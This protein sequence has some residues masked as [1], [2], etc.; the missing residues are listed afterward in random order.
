M[1]CFKELE[2]EYWKK[3]I[4]NLRELIQLE[5]DIDFCNS[6]NFLPKISKISFPIVI[7]KKD[8]IEEK[9]GCIAFIKN[10]SN[11]NKIILN[12]KINLSYQ[13]GTKILISTIYSLLHAIPDYLKKEFSKKFEKSIYYVDIEQTFSCFLN[14]QE[15]DNDLKIYDNSHNLAFATF[16]I[17]SLLKYNESHICLT[18]EITNGEIVEVGEILKKLEAVLL[19]ENIEKFFI[20]KANFKEV[21][22][23]FKDTKYKKEIDDNYI[24]INRN[25]SLKKNPLKI[26]GVDSLEDVFIELY[27]VNW[28]DRKEFKEVFDLSYIYKEKIK[29]SNF[30]KIKNIINLFEDSQE[31]EYVE[32][33]KFVELE[34]EDSSK[35]SSERVNYEVIVEDLKKN[36]NSPPNQYNIG[37]KDSVGTGKSTILKKILS[38]F[39]E[40]EKNDILPVF[41]ELALYTSFFCSKQYEKL[42]YNSLYQLFSN[43]D[44]RNAFFSYLSDNKEKLLFFLDAFDELNQNDTKFNL[45]SDN[46]KFI[47][48]SR[49]IASADSVLPNKTYKL[50][51]L[52]DDAIEAFID[53]NLQGDNFFSFKSKIKENNFSNLND[54]L[55]NPLMLS[56]LVFIVKN[57]K[58][59]EYNDLLNNTIRTRVVAKAVEILIEKSISGNDALKADI[60]VGIELKN[61]FE[62]QVIPNN[63]VSD[64]ILSNIGFDFFTN[65]KDLTLKSDFDD[66]FSKEV[67]II[68]NINLSETKSANLHYMET[69]NRILESIYKN[70]RLLELTLIE[71]DKKQIEGYRFSHQLFKE[72]FTAN[73]VV[74]DFSDNLELFEKWIN[75]NKFNE[76]YLEVIPFVGGILD[77]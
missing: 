58:E 62:G 4:E 27:G 67:S 5:R 44:E 52:S 6:G 55:R 26:I 13:T 8:S 24:I 70:T 54:F 14:I 75:N 32:L 60:G 59:E 43:E 77:M 57:K 30:V 28:Y 74:Y 18:G 69:R 15:P 50:L 51:S 72:Y 9:I 33:E 1:P 63:R 64:K 31:A 12:A 34:L 49:S 21:S 29:N 19:Y 17:L 16:I 37:I 36:F 76:K 7:E 3:K 45:V 25:H 23:K 71:K 2:L 53:K 22:E 68:N 40:K 65:S 66:V 48:T 46:I 61:K 35:T 47:I 39:L 38:C 20:P 73:H 11:N 41:L 42:I 56:L 10:E